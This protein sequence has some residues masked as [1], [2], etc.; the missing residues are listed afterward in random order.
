MWK[1]IM[2][3]TKAVV[4][5]TWSTIIAL[6]AHVIERKKQCLFHSAQASVFSSLRN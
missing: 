1:K 6:T 5:N 4:A 3:G 2:L